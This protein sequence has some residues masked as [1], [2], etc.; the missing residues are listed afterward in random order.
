MNIIDI[1]H[2]IHPKMPNYP[3]S[4]KIEI[5]TF[6]GKSSTSSA[7]I[8]GSH[9]GTHV[10]APRHVFRFGPGVDAMP[11]EA[12]VG[13]C[14]VLDLSYVKEAIQIADLKKYKIQKGERIIVKT[15]NSSRGFKKFFSDYIYLSGDAAQYLGKIGISLFGIDYLSVKQKGSADNRP[16]T[17]LLKRKIVIFEGLNLAKV[18]QGKY[19]FVGLPL[20]FEGLDGS[21]VRAILIPMKVG[22]KI[23]L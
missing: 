20:K 23:K 7:I 19:F 21:P 11:L 10:D 17:E 18:K 6:P 12:M 9:T 13:M 3:G 14:R 22:Y 4:P 2:V 16:H 8:L 5:K 15:K 1:S